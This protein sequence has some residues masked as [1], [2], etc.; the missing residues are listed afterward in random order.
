MFFDSPAAESRSCRAHHTEQ[1]PRDCAK[2]ELLESKLVSS[3]VSSIWFPM[4]ENVS[5]SWP[6]KITF[7][8][9]KPPQSSHISRNAMEGIITQHPRS[10]R[11]GHTRSATRPIPNR[12]SRSNS[13]SSVP[14]TPT[15]LWREVSD[16]KGLDSTR[17]TVGSEK[18]PRTVLDPERVRSLSLAPETGPRS[19]HKSI[20]CC[21]VALPSPAL[22]SASGLLSPS[23]SFR[24][25]G[26]T[27]WDQ[28]ECAFLRPLH[29]QKHINQYIPLV[30]SLSNPLR[31]LMPPM[32]W[33]SI[34]TPA[35]KPFQKV[36]WNFQRPL[37]SPAL[38]TKLRSRKRCD[39]AAE[40]LS[41]KAFLTG[42]LRSH[43]RVCSKDTLLKRL[44][45]ARHWASESN[46]DAVFES[47][48]SLVHDDYEMGHN[49][50]ALDD[51]S[52]PETVLLR[53]R[54]DFDDGDDD[55]PMEDAPTTKCYQLRLF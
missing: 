12:T 52:F 53:D 9:T 14:V 28:H 19:K 22:P 7:A 50:A 18:C 11:S 21:G 24:P 55:R 2:R 47:A 4:N 27:Q 48:L 6:P 42:K 13:L 36:V 40:P 3:P 10:T 25:S 51:S 30:V 49:D 1:Y 15:S 37:P 8:D 20:A 54:D 5:S 29:A 17:K 16:L 45:L 46:E 39:T 31:A 41:L 35:N 44:L 26:L 23:T 43:C 33:K 32:Y 38:P 34:G